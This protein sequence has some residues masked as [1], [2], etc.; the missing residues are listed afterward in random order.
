MP[1][2]DR[3]SLLKTIEAGLGLPCLNHACDSNVNVMTGL[4]DEAGLQPRRLERA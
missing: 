4:L 3:F 2:Y 1:L